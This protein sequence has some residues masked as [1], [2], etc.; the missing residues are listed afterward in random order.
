MR[1]QIEPNHPCFAGHFP[2]FPILPGVLVLEAVLAEVEKTLGIPVDQHQMVNVKFLAAVL[3]GDQLQVDLA[4]SSS[5][6]YK[7]VV[8]VFGQT[9]DAIAQVACTGALR[10][11]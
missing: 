2:N 8:Q 3:P 10:L 11:K 4:S 5:T 9:P 6:E 7:V 1:K